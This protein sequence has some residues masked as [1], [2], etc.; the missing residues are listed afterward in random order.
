MTGDGRGAGAGTGSDVRPTGCGGTGTGL[1][2]G[3]NHSACA[4][5][6]AI[7][8]VTTPARSGAGQP[9]ALQR[10]EW[11]GSVGTDRHRHPGRQEAS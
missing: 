10:G 5:C 1:S 8:H 2:R 3:S 6:L 7:I 9:S 4:V 11:N